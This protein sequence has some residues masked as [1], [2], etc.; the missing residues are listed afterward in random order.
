MTAAGTATRP[1]SVQLLRYFPPDYFAARAG[2]R[3]LVSGTN[4]R[5]RSFPLRASGPAGEQLSVDCVYLGNA[6][7]Q[8]LLIISTGIHGIEGFAGSAV[9]QCFLTELNRAP[10]ITPGI[11]LVHALNPYGFAHLRRVNENNVDLNRNALPSFPGPANAGYARLERLL[12]PRSAPTRDSALWPGLLRYALSHG[13]AATVQAIAGGQYEFPQ[14]L[15]YGGAQPEESLAI[16]AQIL[17]DAPCKRL[18]T[19]VHIDVHTG[20]GAYGRYQLLSDLPPGAPELERLYDWFGADHIVTGGTRRSPPY[21]AR[22]SIGSLTARLLSTAQMYVL[23]L[24]FGTYS[25]LRMLRLLRAENRLHHHGDPQSEIGRSI[26]RRLLESFCPPDERW[27]TEVV[28][29]GTRVLQQ[30]LSA[31]A[32]MA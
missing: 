14:G 11:L 18:Q 12:S 17:A 13:R 26:K 29:Q 4:A 19:V 5:A 20:L 1:A 25:S 7:P 15:F 32:N 21:Y 16:F 10:A 9:L 3:R 31:L 2:F 6:E 22:G 8:R 24:E 27:R 23:T 30:G 28:A